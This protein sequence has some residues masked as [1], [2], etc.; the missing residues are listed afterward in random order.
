MKNERIV[1]CD[2]IRA[3]AALAVILYH[4]TYRY[5]VL[6]HSN[7][8]YKITVVYGAAG[9]NIFFFLSGFLGLYSVN[10]KT[11]CVDYMKRRFNRLYPEY[12][13]C[14]VITA[15]FLSLFF[16]E[17]FLGWK[18]VLFNVTMLQG[19]IGV[20][21][22]DGAYWTLAYELRF[23]IFIFVVIASKKLKHIKSIC[24]LWVII[25]MT[26]FF[27]SSF[28]SST[29]IIKLMEYIIMPKYCA[30]F[31]AGIFVYFLKNRLD[32]VWCYFGLILSFIS[33]F[34]MQEPSYFFA[35]LVIVVIMIS[36]FVLRNKCDRYKEF[37]LKASNTKCNPLIYIAQ[38][39]Y[40]VY[41]LHQYIG[42]AILQKIEN[43]G[44][45]NEIFIIL[46]I[47]VVFMLAHIVNKVLKKGEII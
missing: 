35:L 19:F 39:S 29:L 45:N 11:K 25:S 34:L 30:P 27:L 26:V 20:S 32:D 8:D 13:M 41:L 23:Y 22:L 21:N 5:P 17:L 43:K 28:I 4:Y 37:I 12:W 7:I 14:M 24:I 42:Y 31:V 40:P 2:W 44:F 33:S 3:I 18:V 46:P 1:E 16:N 47:V 9:V 36:V 6:F 38:I 15:I 10:E